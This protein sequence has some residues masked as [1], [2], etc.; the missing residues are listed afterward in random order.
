MGWT[1]FMTG[2]ACERPHSLI[3]LSLEGRGQR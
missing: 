2:G 1:S 3:F